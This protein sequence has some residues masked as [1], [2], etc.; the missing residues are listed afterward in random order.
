MSEWVIQNWEYVLVVFYSVEKIV[1]MTP[2][3]YDDILF[4]MLLKPIKEK[5]SPSK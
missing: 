5:I 1:K 2:T 3:K 4:D